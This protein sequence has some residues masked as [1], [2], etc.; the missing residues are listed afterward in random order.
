MAS[1]ER[2]GTHLAKLHGGVVVLEGFGCSSCGEGFWV[3]AN[4][5]IPDNREF[6][7]PTCG[8][9]VTT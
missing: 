8:K 4:S 7:C 6:H 3:E 1:C 5:P 2:L 9:K